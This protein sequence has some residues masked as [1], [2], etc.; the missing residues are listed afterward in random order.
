SGTL[1]RIEPDEAAALE[2]PSPSVAAAEGAA[3]TAPPPTTTREVGYGDFSL[4]L[5]ESADGASL[6]VKYEHKQTVAAQNFKVWVIPCYVKADLKIGI[7]GEIVV[8]GKGD[9][10]LNVKSGGALELGI[11]GTSEAVTAGPYGEVALTSSSTVPT[12]LSE[13]REVAMDPFVLDVYGTG[14]VGIKFELK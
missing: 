4:G 12:R 1:A 7:E 11:G 13:A 14:K 8:K 3:Q 2:P 6:I 5:K 10:Q 9:R